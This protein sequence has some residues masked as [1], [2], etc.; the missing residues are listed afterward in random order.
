ML[1]YPYGYSRVMS[2]FF[3]DDS[4]QGPPQDR[5]ENILSPTINSDGTC[6]NGWVCEHRWREIFNMVEFRNVVAGTDYSSNLVTF[7]QCWYFTENIVFVNIARWAS[8]IWWKLVKAVTICCGF[9]NLVKLTPYSGM[10][11]AKWR[12]IWNIINS[13]YYYEWQN[14][15][16]RAF[17]CVRSHVNAR[18]FVCLCVCVCVR[19]MIGALSLVNF[20]PI[21]HQ[22]A[23]I[24]FVGTLLKT[25]LQHFVFQ[26]RCVK[27][28]IQS[29]VTWI[30]LVEP[31]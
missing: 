26:Q 14:A 28:N 5:N 10:Y 13:G 29:D 31:L 17:L 7:H 1:A 27:Q 6:G 18:L 30:N 22:P 4:D 19:A 24:L 12:R 20:H 15:C 23:L 9:F 3:F 2:S 11:E 8:R 16:A 21:A 25:E